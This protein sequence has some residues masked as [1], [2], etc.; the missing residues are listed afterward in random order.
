MEIDEI[1]EYSV[2]SGIIGSLFFLENP[3][4]GFVIFS[5]YVIFIAAFLKLFLLYYSK[6]NEY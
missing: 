1:I 4:K 5:Y 6:D 3:V 2:I